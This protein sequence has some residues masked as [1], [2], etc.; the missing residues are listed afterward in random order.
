MK[1]YK[2]LTDQKLVRMEESIEREVKVFGNVQIS[3]KEVIAMKVD[4]EYRMYKRID[5]IDLDW[6]TKGG[7]LHQFLYPPPQIVSLLT[8]SKQ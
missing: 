7:I 8:P 1:I 6:S 3:E 4:P 5:E 2:I